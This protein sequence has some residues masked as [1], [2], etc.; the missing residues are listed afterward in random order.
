MISSKIKEFEFEK[1]TNPV[2]MLESIKLFPWKSLEIC[3][4]FKPSAQFRNISE[5]F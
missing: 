5:I 1:K 4:T 2:I 3:R